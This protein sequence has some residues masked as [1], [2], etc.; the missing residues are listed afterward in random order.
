MS[1]LSQHKAILNMAF[2]MNF[3]FINDF[4]STFIVIYDHVFALLFR[5]SEYRKS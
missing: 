2:K 3:I 4:Y 5:N 1:Q